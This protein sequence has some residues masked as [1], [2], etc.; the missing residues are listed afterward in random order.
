MIKKK[1]RQKPAKIKAH[2]PEIGNSV[3][4]HKGARVLP[5]LVTSENEDGTL[6][7]V[8]F[9]DSP[10]NP[11]P[12]FVRNVLAEA[13]LPEQEDESAPADCWSR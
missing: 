11:T 9:D 12:I 13:D 2:N 4:Y 7:L 1:L 10:E 8:A 3:L 5:A 6:N